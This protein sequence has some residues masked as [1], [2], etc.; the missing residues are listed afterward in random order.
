MLLLALSPRPVDSVV[1]NRIG[2]IETFSLRLL[3]C[4]IFA[5]QLVVQREDCENVS[6]KFLLPCCV[7]TRNCFHRRDSLFSC[8]ILA[9]IHDF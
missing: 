6:F 3:I 9:V 2:L 8:E 5:F 1:V 7:Y 4:R